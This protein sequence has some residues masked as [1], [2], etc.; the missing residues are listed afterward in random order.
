MLFDSL[1]SEYTIR[2]INFLGTFFVENKIEYSRVTIR[3]GLAGTVP[4][5]SMTSRCLDYVFRDSI[6]SRKETSIIYICLFLDTV[7]KL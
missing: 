2:S 6:L 5:S 1:S 7:E 4:V 3:P